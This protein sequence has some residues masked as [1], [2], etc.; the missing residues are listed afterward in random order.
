MLPKL[1]ISSFLLANFPGWTGAC[2]FSSCFVYVPQASSLPGHIFTC[3]EFVDVGM[4][5]LLKINEN[6]VG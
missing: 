5:K 4:S 6:L 3:S 1:L 2:N